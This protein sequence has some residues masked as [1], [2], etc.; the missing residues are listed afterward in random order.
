MGSKNFFSL[1]S[2]KNQ[3]NFSGGH[4]TVVTS[5]EMPGLVNISLSHLK[6]NKNA[7]LEPMWHPNAN[8]IG[9]CL[10]GTTLVSIRSPSGVDVFTVSKGDVFFIPQGYVHTLSNTGNMESV[11]AF[12][13]NSAKPQEMYFSKAVYS[14]SDSV[15]TATFDTPANFAEGLK[16]NKKQE[17]IKTLS[18]SVKTPSTISSRFKFNIEDS[19]KIIKTK[20]G[21]VQAAL[22]DNLS[23][24]VGLSILGFGLTPGGVVEPHW[25]TNAGELIY[26]T[27]GQTRVTVVS[28]D[29]NVE[30]LEVKAGQ[31]AF[32]AASHFHNIENT[33][34]DD[35]E[36]IA[37]FSDAQPDFI[38]IG[39]V[40]GSYSNEMLA[41][42]FNVSPNYFDQFKK[43]SGPLVIVPVTQ[44]VKHSTKKE[45]DREAYAR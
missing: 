22:K 38:G 10:Q 41:S 37:F 28:P 32:A 39:E 16:K 20:G 25:H 43:P 21:Y 42:I 23:P 11:I 27:K 13:L 8:K 45:Q 26:I 18:A 35:V 40:L 4:Y 36:V 17:L 44:E 14:L 31:G 33:G 7:F 30:A 3:K 1:D 9:Y 29:G 19:T 2:I 24:L 12:A 6:L 15:F 5:D 34:H